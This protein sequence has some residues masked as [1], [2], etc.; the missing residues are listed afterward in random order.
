MSSYQK[1]SVEHD[2]T[3]KEADDGVGQG[4]RVD[5]D[6]PLVLGDAF[7]N[8]FGQPGQTKTNLRQDRKYILFNVL[9]LFH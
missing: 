8:R 2:E 5:D 1:D 3:E 6:V 4:R 9:S 7:H